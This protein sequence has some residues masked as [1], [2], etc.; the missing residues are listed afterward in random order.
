M[1]PVAKLHPF[2]VAIAVG[3]FS[4]SWEI[5]ASVLNS[6]IGG[7]MSLGSVI[8]GNMTI[9]AYT[10]GV[11]SMIVLELINLAIGFFAGA[12]IGLLFAFFYNIVFVGLLAKPII[13]A[14]GL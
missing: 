8:S 9:G 13:K 3:V 2:S 1:K 5:I 4:I 6:V 14:E 7:V 10:G 11:A 12:L